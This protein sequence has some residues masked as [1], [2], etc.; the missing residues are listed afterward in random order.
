MPRPHIAMR[1]I[2]D[3]LRLTLGEGLGLRQVAAS[4]GLPHTTV[5]NYARR[6]RKAGLTWPLPADMDDDALEAA[7][8]AKPVPLA[9]PRPVPDWEKVH[10]EL[11]RPASRSCCCGTSTKSSSQTATRIP[12][13]LSVTRPGHGTWVSSCAK[14][15]GRAR[16]CSS[17]SRA[18]KIPIYEANSGQVAFEAELFVAAMGASSYLYAEA[19]PSQELLYWVTA[20]VHAFEAMGACPAIVVCD[21]LRSRV[22]RPHRYEP[23]VDATYAEMA[24]HYGVAVIPARAYRPRDKA[25]WSC[26]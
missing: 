11:R 17:T 3:A 24:A 8:F 16:S 13:S 18:T 14:S 21:N 25:K 19:F 20:H 15:T 6:A 5:A 1:K 4:L 7:L 2:R 23:D 12:S 22:T 10:M 9:G 26:S